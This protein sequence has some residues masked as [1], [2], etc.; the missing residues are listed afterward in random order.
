MIPMIL[1]EKFYNILGILTI[2][3]KKFAWEWEP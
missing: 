1:Q 3:Y 2:L